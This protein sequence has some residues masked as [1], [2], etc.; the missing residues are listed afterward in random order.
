MDNDTEFMTVTVD[1]GDY[2][3]AETLW[4][5]LQVFLG[6]VVG[7]PGRLTR[8]SRTDGGCNYRSAGMYRL[9]FVADSGQTT[10]IILALR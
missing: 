7:E 4:E 9:E 2:R 8:I 5:P 1:G 6:A 10:P 3:R